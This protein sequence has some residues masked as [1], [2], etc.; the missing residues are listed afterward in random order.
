MDRRNGVKGVLR[1]PCPHRTFFEPQ[2][3]SPFAAAFAARAGYRISDRWFRRRR[4]FASTPAA[5]AATAAVGAVASGGGESAEAYAIATLCAV[6]ITLFQWHCRRRSS[7][8]ARVS[9]KDTAYRASRCG[10]GCR[11]AAFAS[12]FAFRA[13]AGGGAASFRISWRRLLTVCTPR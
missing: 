6:Y 4:Q 8:G 11:R 2:H 9:V 10:V 3:L 5:V 12:N 7:L 1:S 13:D